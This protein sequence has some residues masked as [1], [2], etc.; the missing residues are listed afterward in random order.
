[1]FMSQLGNGSI[2]GF[3]VSLAIGVVS[4]VFTA[5]VVSRLIFDFGTDVLK[6]QKVSI[7]WKKYGAAA[8]QGGSI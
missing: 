8:I 5:L 4:S 1:M 7:T 3:A 6:E 2:Q